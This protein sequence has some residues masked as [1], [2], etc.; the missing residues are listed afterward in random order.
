VAV[1]PSVSC[2]R[3]TCNVYV[4]RSGTDA[5]LVDFGDG[6]VLDHLDELGVERVTDV[7]LTHHHRDQLGGLDRAV[8]AGI[9]IWAPPTEVE[10]IARVD[11][12]WARRQIA[13]D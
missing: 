6:D 1:A 7:L 8:E 11:E 5:I 4:L 12:H 2:F 10:L 9:R 3:D 13:N